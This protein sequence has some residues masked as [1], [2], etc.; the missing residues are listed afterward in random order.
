MASKL[1]LDFSN[2]QMEDLGDMNNIRHLILSGICITPPLFLCAGSTPQYPVCGPPRFKKH[3]G[4][5]NYRPLQAHFPAQ[6][7]TVGMLGT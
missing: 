7:F 3:P 4:R 6:N 1:T 2:T 5:G